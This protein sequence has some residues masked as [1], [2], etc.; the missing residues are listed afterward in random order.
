ARLRAAGIEV[1]TG[2]EER[3]ALEADPAFFF[4][5]GA[6]RPWITL[7]LALTIDGAIADKAGH[8]Q[9]ITGAKARAAA[10]ELRAGHDAI[11]VG[12]GTV[13]ADN[14]SLTVRDAPAPRIPP[15][16]VIF[17][18]RARTPLDSE[19]VRTA[20]QIPVIV[21]AEKPPARSV[22]ELETAGVQVVRTSSLY[23]R[24]EHLKSQEGIRSLLV[25]GGARLASALWERSLVDRLIIFQGPV[26]LGAG[27]LGA[28]GFAPGM[29][30]EEAARLRVLE[31]RA[32]GDDS[33]ISYAVHDVPAPGSPK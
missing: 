28:F 4:S 18:R 30:I 16:R 12:L 14:P 22:R 9:W 6:K 26:V 2:V 13:L 29:T 20:R 8:S 27:S 23:N 10:H 21:M 33:M 19:L 1:V 5:F 24:L 3:R 31:R 15:R 7:K 11:A 32:F 17:D 25:E